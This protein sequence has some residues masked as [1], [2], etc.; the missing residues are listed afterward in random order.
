[1]PP[2]HSADSMPVRQKC[3]PWM[4][5]SATPTH[6]T[7]TTTPG[8]SDAAPIA[9]VVRKKNTI[10]TRSDL[11][12][13]APDRSSSG[14]GHTFLKGD[15]NHKQSDDSRDRREHDQQWFGGDNI[16]RENCVYECVH[17]VKLPLLME[18]PHDRAHAE[19]DRH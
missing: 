4:S 3:F 2:I 19:G 7:S 6:T 17:N 12:F 14:P 9:I 8:K 1:M 10:S 11:R 16:D 13:Q 5:H 15:M 18:A